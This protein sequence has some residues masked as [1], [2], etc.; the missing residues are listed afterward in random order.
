ML[1]AFLA[2]TAGGSIDDTNDE[3]NGPKIVRLGSGGTGGGG[4]GNGGIDI[5]IH[6]IV[7]G[8]Y[9]AMTGAGGLDGLVGLMS[10]PSNTLPTTT[11]NDSGIDTFMTRPS[12]V[13]ND[14]DKDELGLFSDLYAEGGAQSSSNTDSASIPFDT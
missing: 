5:H 1:S 2:S 8:P 4:N 14:D 13:I 9:G 7:T 6:A 10:P 3:G 11:N 12:N